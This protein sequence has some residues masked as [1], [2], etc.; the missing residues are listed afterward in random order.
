[1]DDDEADDDGA[2]VHPSRPADRR[3][4]DDHRDDGGDD[5]VREQPNTRNGS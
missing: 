1:V 3:D 5:L 2:R 4:G